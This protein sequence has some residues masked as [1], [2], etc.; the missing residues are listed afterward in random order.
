MAYQNIRIPPDSVGKRVRHD[1]ELLINFDNGT[2]DFSE[3]DTVTFQTSQVSGTVLK[4]TTGSTGTLQVLLLPESPATVVDGENIQVGGSTYATAD[5]TGTLYYLPIVAL[6]GGNNPNRRSRIDK[7]GGLH[8][9]TKHGDFEITNTGRLKSSE[10]IVLSRLDFTREKLTTEV[11]E[12]VKVSGAV[13]FDDDW[14]GVKMSTTNASGSYIS[15]SQNIYNLIDFIYG[16]EVIMVVQHGDTGKSNHI[17]RWGIFDE[18]NGMFFELNGTT[19]YVGYRSSITGTTTDTKIAQDSWN[20][21]RVDGNSGEFNLSEVNLDIT[22]S[23]IYFIEY[24]F[25]ASTIKWGVIIDDERIICHAYNWT[26]TEIGTVFQRGN[27]PLNWQMYNTGST[28]GGSEMRI[29]YGVCSSE[30]GLFEV[31]F[32]I[33]S[34]M[35]SKSVSGSDWSP[36]LSIRPSQTYKNGGTLDNREWII[37]KKLV[38]FSDTEP[39]ALRLVASPTLV[40]ASWTSGP[41]GTSIETDTASTSADGGTVYCTEFVGAGESRE[42]IIVENIKPTSLKLTRKYDITEIPDH[43]TIEVKSLNESITNVWMNFT[44]LETHQ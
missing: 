10:E 15:K 23:N 4:S 29:K 41:S 39:I 17:R 31:N 16:T 36:M 7:Y 18:K 24:S 13:V 2:Q 20:T 9:K 30:V 26:N 22:K 3:G 1:V 8:V 14:A 34:Y 35:T 43:F 38:I 28:S 44:Y 42:V 37:P 21:D 6:I 27:L 25:A 40:G 12:T 5:G 33:G 32:N 11:S 19:M